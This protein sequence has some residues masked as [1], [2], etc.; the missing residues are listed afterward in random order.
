MK[1]QKS[2]LGVMPMPTVKPSASINLGEKMDLPDVQ[3]GQ[4][5]TVTLK[6]TV[7]GMRADEFGKSLDL[8]VTAVKAK[9]PRAESLSQDMADLKRSRTMD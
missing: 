3:V 7:R 5:V 1:K 8:T 9:G 2:D 6:G 4:T